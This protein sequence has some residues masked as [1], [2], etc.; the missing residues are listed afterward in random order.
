MA[1]A[2]QIT[3]EEYLRT[4]FRPDAEY[5]K[6]EV[7]ERNVGEYDH[8]VVQW[9]I[10]DWFRRHDKEWLTRTLQE[11]R[12]RLKTGNVRVPDIAVWARNAPIEPV[13][14]HA[15]MVV[16]E[17]LSPEDR[18]YR[19][20]ARIE[21][22]RQAGVAHIWVVDPTRR[23]GWDCSDGNW[24]AKARFGVTD[25]AAYLDLPDLFKALDE[26]EA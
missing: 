19:V 6:G 23:V 3:L 14:S 18:Q 7:Q 2:V 11:Q 10:L 26:A 13:F 22:Y 16:V 15:P 17:V 24:T 8:T 1:T 4:S 21:D 20:Q 12:T 5:V 25:S 9:A